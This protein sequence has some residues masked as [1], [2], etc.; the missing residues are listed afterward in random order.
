MKGQNVKQA[1][2]TKPA[3]DAIA[4]KSEQEAFLND[5]ALATV[6]AEIAEIAQTV[7]SA[8]DGYGPLAIAVSRWVKSG[9]IK[10][11]ETVKTRGK[12]KA[13]AAPQRDIYNTIATL[14]E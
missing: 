13:G 7:G 3:T 10:H 12:R 11:P 2:S 6:A 5:T 4:S 9:A 1:Q 8:A 14:A